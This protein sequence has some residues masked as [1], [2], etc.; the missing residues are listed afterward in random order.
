MWE[1]DIGVQSLGLLWSVLLGI[2]SAVFYD[3]LRAI[4]KV[5][6]PN[7]V[8]VFVFDVFY[9]II[10]TLLFFIY[11]MVFTNGQ[12]RMFTILGAASGFIFSF[13]GLSKITFFIFV[14]ILNV[15]KF[16]FNKIKGFFKGVGAV[17][18]KIVIF[19]KKTS[20]NMPFRAKKS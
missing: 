17:F 5:F 3:V 20:K 16:F 8:L 14:K 7:A 12:V 2:I 11:F 15:F 18:M 10:L 1:I 19:F 4:N 13:L 9:W 6:R